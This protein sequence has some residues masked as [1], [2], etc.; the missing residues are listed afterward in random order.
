MLYLNVSKQRQSKLETT[1]GSVSQAASGTVPLSFSGVGI[2]TGD[3]RVFAIVSLL[4]TS[5]FS[6]MIIASIK[7][8]NIKSGVRY[9]PIFMT[10]SLVVY[11]IAVKA[12]GYLLGFV[13]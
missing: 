1:L 3:F 7:K 5:F 4:V 8:G 6:S 2:S 12:S 9:I 11:F 10:V 13:F